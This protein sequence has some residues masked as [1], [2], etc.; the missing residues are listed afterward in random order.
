M[1]GVRVRCRLYG[2]CGCDV[3]CMVFVYDVDCM[4]FECDVR[5]RLYGT[6]MWLDDRGLSVARCMGGR[7]PG[8]LNAA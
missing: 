3:D 4:V 6:C 1:Y 8:W 7:M 2:V 5:C